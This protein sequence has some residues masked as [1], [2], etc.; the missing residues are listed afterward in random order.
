[1]VFVSR[2]VSSVWSTSAQ[3]PS[4]T[5]LA[6]S[7]TFRHLP[8]TLLAASATFPA[9]SSTFRHLPLALASLGASFFDG[10]KARPC[11]VGT[12]GP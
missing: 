9:A 1:M 7:A 2:T 8:G 5:F 6:P 11:V 4:A 3:A 10:T 12:P